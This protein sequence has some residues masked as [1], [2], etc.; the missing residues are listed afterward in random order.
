VAEWLD[1]ARKLEDNLRKLNEHL[2][3]MKN[4][5]SALSAAGSEKT[6]YS[7][8]MRLIS[9]LTSAVSSV[10]VPAQSLEEASKGSSSTAPHVLSYL[11]RSTIQIGD[12]PNLE[13]YTDQQWV[14]H[15]LGLLQSPG[16]DFSARFVRIWQQVCN[17]TDESLKG[18]VRSWG[19]YA[20][21]ASEVAALPGEIDRLLS[22]QEQE[23][24]WVS[25]RAALEVRKQD[26]DLSAKPDLMSVE[27]A[28]GRQEVQR[29][30]LVSGIYAEDAKE[31]ADAGAL[32]LP[33]IV[34]T[35]AP[36]MLIELAPV[37]VEKGLTQ[38]P[39]A[40]EVPA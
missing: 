25:L 8:L 36:A 29:F 14:E 18:S 17:R 9:R 28:D 19:L 11:A 15:A 34:R 12:Q 2:C 7:K 26:F 38:L 4:S 1:R 20:D 33:D 40:K 21:F 30:L 23:S 35:A 27:V 13:N 16:K 6:G 22:Q 24:P 37:C 32:L 39:Q 31:M 3:G 5:A 10:F